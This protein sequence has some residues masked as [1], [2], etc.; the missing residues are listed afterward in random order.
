MMVKMTMVIGMDNKDLM[1]KEDV[2]DK[3]QW[4]WRCDEDDIDGLIRR[5]SIIIVI[6]IMIVMIIMLNSLNNQIF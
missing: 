1:M 2:F 4:W 5:S 6:V 3:Y